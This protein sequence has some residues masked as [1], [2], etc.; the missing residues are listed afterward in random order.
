MIFEVEI[1]EFSEKFGDLGTVGDM[2][3]VVR[4]DISYN[5]YKMHFSV[6]P[7]KCTKLCFIFYW[8]YGISDNNKN[9]MS[10]F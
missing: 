9:K 3:H 7:T 10:Y 2:F 8:L 5:P 1:R 6:L 4:S